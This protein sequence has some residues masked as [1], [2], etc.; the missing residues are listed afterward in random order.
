MTVPEGLPKRAAKAMLEGKYAEAATMI[1]DLESHED[2]HAA[3]DDVHAL[4]ERV[5][6]DQ[7][8]EGRTDVDK[9]A[10]GIENLR[11]TLRAA[12]PATVSSGDGAGGRALGW[13]LRWGLPIAALAG[14]WWFWFRG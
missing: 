9:A 4:L 14:A 2:Q 1:A 8:V 10:R 6:I 5:A 13:L 11:A 7:Q 12:R 3:L